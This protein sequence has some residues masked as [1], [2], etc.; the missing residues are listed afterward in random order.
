MNKRLKLTI[1]G[2]VTAIVVGGGS[3][4]AVAATSS[5]PVLAPNKLCYNAG[6]QVIAVH[7][8]CPP[9]YKTYTLAVGQ[10]GP[11]GASGAR[12]VT[13]KTGPQG[14]QGVQGQ[15]GKNGS[16][17]V[18]W[19]DTTHMLSLSGPVS[20]ATGG[21][22]VANATLV[23]TLTFATAGYW[24][25]QINAQATPKASGD[26]AQIFPQLFVYTQPKNSN[27]D[28]DLF[29]IGSGALQPD[30]TNHNSYLN[31]S[32]T[33]FI[34]NPATKVYIYAFGYDSDTGAGSYTLNY[35]NVTNTEFV[36]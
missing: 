4:A 7:N 33:V 18:V 6:G 28:G 23:G 31:G 1:A 17:G 36:S 30:G 3:L 8:V 35:V 14:I 32:M 12:G 34:A 5:G 29:N 21:G 10:R 19:N 24:D 11:K 15:P 13:G 16:S 2:A 26:T 22:F 20:V 25:I 27:F 9:K